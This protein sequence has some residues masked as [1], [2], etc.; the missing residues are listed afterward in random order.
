M[1]R[2]LPDRVVEPNNLFFI[3]CGTQDILNK[4]TEDDAD[5]DKDKK[6]ND[7]KK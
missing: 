4:L 2:L 7:K 1:S 3:L 6:K 5:K